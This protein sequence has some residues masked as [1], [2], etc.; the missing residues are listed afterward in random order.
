MYV[1]QE[2]ALP[3]SGRVS[4]MQENRI[5][6]CCGML[7]VAVVENVAEMAWFVVTLSKV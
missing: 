3:L 2:P 6:P 7:P 4:V 1:A 5:C